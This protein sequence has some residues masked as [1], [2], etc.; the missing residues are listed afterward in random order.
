MD[1]FMIK[2]RG[3]KLSVPLIVRYALQQLSGLREVQLHNT[4]CMVLYCIA[5]KETDNTSLCVH[6]DPN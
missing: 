2:N 1:V 6:L 4:F 5:I 3:L